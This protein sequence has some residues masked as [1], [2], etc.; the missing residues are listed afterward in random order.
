MINLILFQFMRMHLVNRVPWE[1][2]KCFTEGSHLCDL[3]C[4]YML[5][6]SHYARNYYLS[7]KLNPSHGW[8]GDANTII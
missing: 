1:K 6:S 4:E 8:R 7:L 3:L 5:S 2:K